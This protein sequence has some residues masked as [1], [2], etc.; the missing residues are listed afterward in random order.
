M[1]ESK[2]NRIKQKILDINSERWW[3]DNYDVRF[4]LTSKLQKIKKK[5]ILDVGGGIGIIL[6]ELDESNFRINLD[7]SFNDLKICKNTDYRIQNI[8]GSMTNLPFINEFVDCIICSH[9]LEIAKQNDIE[10]KLIQTNSDNKYPTVQKTISEIY[11]VLK[12][13]G[14]LFLTTPNN[15]YYRTIKFTFGELENAIL[16]LFSEAKIFFFNTYPKISK[17][18]RKL[19][20]ANLVPKI[21]SKLLNDDDVIKSLIKTTSENNYSVS[22]YV[23]A[24]RS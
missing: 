21:R 5:S 9:L 15:E 24:K 1:T 11:R 10:K 19:N 8:C 12:Q 20:M 4:Y 14:M 18:Y 7:S 16:P 2:R 13:N 22:F 23:E 3:G 17:K 6:S